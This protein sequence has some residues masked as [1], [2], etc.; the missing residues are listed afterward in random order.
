MNQRRI[1]KSGAIAVAISLYRSL[2]DLSALDRPCSILSNIYQ[3]A[4]FRV[5][6]A[7]VPHEEIVQKN[8]KTLSFKL[9]QTATIIYVHRQVGDKRSDPKGIL[10]YYYKYA[11]FQGSTTNGLPQLKIYNFELWIYRDD[12]PH[13]LRSFH[14]GKKFWNNNNWHYNYS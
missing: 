14:I 2:N 1:C 6:F 11:H 10:F 7:A 12:L 13:K 3:T 4:L 9:K 5:I 8:P